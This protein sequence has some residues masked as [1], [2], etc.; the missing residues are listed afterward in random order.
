MLP[1]FL[2]CIAGYLAAAEPAPAALSGDPATLVATAVISSVTG[3]ESTLKASYGGSE[4]RL[5]AVQPITW[6]LDSP[7]C[8][9]FRISGGLALPFASFGAVRTVGLAAFLCRPAAAGPIL[10]SGDGAPLELENPK[11]AAY[12]GATLGDDFGFLCLAPVS[13]PGNSAYGAWVSPRGGGFS[14]IAAG[15]G[16]IAHPNGDDWYDPPEPA[17]ERVWAAA[18]AEAGGRLWAIAAA[19]ALGASFPGMD[20]FAG[21]VEGWMRL[22]AVRFEAEASSASAYWRGLDGKA[23]PPFRVDTGWRYTRRGAAL[24]GGWRGVQAAF[25]EGLD[26][27]ATGYVEAVGYLGRGRASAAIGADSGGD[28][29]VLELETRFRPAITPWLSLSTSWRVADGKAERFDLEAQARF[30]RRL[31]VLMEAGVRMVPEGTLIDCA[32]EGTVP[33]PMASVSI[34]VRTI[35]WVEPA[36]LSPGSLEYRIRA[37][38]SLR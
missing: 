31:P 4:I 8:E 17:A 7:A 10:L 2:A 23:A 5:W 34:G 6:P 18:S 1:L 25:G 20:F 36:S 3:V 38:L 14:A 15:G 27:T 30:G 22:G 33:L 19:G 13:E 9:P 28:L 12:L 11:D 26:T 32:V 24:G 21:R 16:E 29:P 35:G 37:R